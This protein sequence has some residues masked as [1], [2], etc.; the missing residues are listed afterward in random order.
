MVKGTVKVAYWDTEQEGG[1]P[2]LLGEIK[3]TP[4]IRLFKPKKK[5]GPSNK[6]K[7]VVDYNYERKAKDMKRFVDE[8]MPNFIEKVNSPK[9]LTSFEEKAARN[10]LPRAILFTSKSH[11]SALTKYLSTEFRRRLLLAEV[12]PTKNNKDIME[13]YGVKDLP[14]LILIPP[15]A[16]EVEKEEIRYDGDSFTRHRLQS[17]LSKYALKE[18]V[19]PKKKEPDEEEKTKQQKEKVHSEL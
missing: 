6:K 13:Q 18:V 3:G 12:P 15:V 4:T 2:P 8:Q 11:T 7:V 1:R 9:D 14:A 10:G 5:Q 16:D 19:F 17:F